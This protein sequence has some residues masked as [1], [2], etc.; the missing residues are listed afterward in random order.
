MKKDKLELILVA[1]IVFLG[2]VASLSQ[3]IYYLI[4]TPHNTSFSFVHNHIEDYYYYLQIMRQGHEGSWLATSYLTPEIS[5]A[6]FVV[7]FFIFLGHLA[8]IFSIS[9]PFAYTL[10][11][12]LGAV[13]LLAG[14][15]LLVKAFY[16]ESRI[17]RM[18]ALLMVVFGTYFWGI[19]DGKP[20][21]AALVH[22]WTELDPLFRGSFIPHHLWA[23][24]MM[25]VSFLLLWQALSE[26]KINWRRSLLMLV[27]V[28]CMGFSSPVILATYIPV[29]VL[30]M[31]LEVRGRL[32]PRQTW[33]GRLA[34]PLWPWL[35]ALI[36][37]LVVT[38]YH[39]IVQQGA[40]PWNSYLEWE[41]VRYQIS[42][43]DYFL[44]LGPNFLLFLVAVPF[45]WRKNT[46][47]RLLIAWA[48]SGWILLFVVGSFVP[49]SNIRYLAGYQFIPIG[50]GA[51][52]GIFILSKKL[53]NLIRFSRILTLTIGITIILMIY[54]SA[55]L[56]ASWQEHKGYVFQN[57]NDFRVYVPEDLTK[58][59]SF[60]EKYQGKDIVVLAPYNLS[61]M[62]PQA[63]SKRV[64]A[65]HTMMTYQSSQKK[66]DQDKFFS[67]KDKEEGKK[68]LERYRVELVLTDNS[69]FDKHLTDLG[70]KIV[71]RKGKYTVYEI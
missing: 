40:F 45:L 35:L 2:V 38:V 48:F 44:S 21:V 58:S 32:P 37:A 43:G 65:G 66:A 39:R 1:I 29:L 20:A 24:V 56:W 11:R 67:F 15:Y 47:G 36:A 25:I 12:I 14:S 19:K 27:S 17:K 6:K 60:I 62:I 68:I 26:K 51:V 64:V 49:L 57:K 8:R 33:L 52:E 50:I 59:L 4:N 9:L 23:K 63:S 28:V 42:P 30:W 69:D 22:Q 55:G 46:L 3:T 61:M 41:K 70:L 10:A 54:F 16:P 34:V 13:A 31:G 5:P 71:Y 7:T 53:D 18:I